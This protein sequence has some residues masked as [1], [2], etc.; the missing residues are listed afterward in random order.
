MKKASQK[1][2]ARQ[3]KRQHKKP[4]VLPATA[5]RYK[6]RPKPVRVPG[7]MEM[8][9]AVMAMGGLLGRR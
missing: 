9:A 7:D 3:R 4:V 2:R 5:R 1:A 6:D 8:M